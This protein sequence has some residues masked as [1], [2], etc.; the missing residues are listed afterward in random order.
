[1]EEWHESISN[2]ATT[3]SYQTLSNVLFINH[4]ITAPQ[5]V[6]PNM[7]IVKK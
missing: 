7:S 2:Q 5:S 1:M 3:T 6:G 4:P